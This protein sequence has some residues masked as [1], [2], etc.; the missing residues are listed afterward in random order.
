MQK[1]LDPNQII[2]HSDMSTP[3]D[4]YANEKISTVYLLHAYLFNLIPTGFM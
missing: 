2:L 4:P 1:V 3:S